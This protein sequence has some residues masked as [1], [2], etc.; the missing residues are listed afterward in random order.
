MKKEKG[1]KAAII[2][3]GQIGST[4]DDDPK[5]KEIWS[6]AGAYGAIE[7]FRSI[8]G[9]DVDPVKRDKFGKRDKVTGVYEDYREMLAKEKIDVLSICSPTP[10]HYEMAKEAL[11]HGLSAI[12]MEKPITM[13]V[14]QGKEI[15]SICHRKKVVLAV[16]HTRRW[17]MDY[18]FPKRLIEK[19]EIGE[20]KSIIGYYS[21]KILNIGTHLID[22]MRLYAGEIKWVVGEYVIKKLEDPTLS[23]YFMFE[24]GISGFLVP[25][26][27]KETLIFELDIIGS[28]GRM[29]VI[30]NGRICE[31]Y[32]Y[33]NSRNYSGYEELER[34]PVNKP[35][36]QGNRLIL[37]IEDII[38][39][40]EGRNRVPACS[41]EDGLKNIAVAHA[42]I[43]SADRKN[44]KVNL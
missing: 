37:A 5:R 39:C 42:L 27:K 8:V 9:S 6:H 12:F 32:K 4:F 25:Q 41:G 31:L 3:L 44:R 1:Y 38:D 30:D 23:G 29:R 16:N 15:V 34:R 18:L 40:F 22:I 7:K 24:Q 17:D 35:K 21:D 14:A 20:V 26:G 43:N 36:K 2:G 19:G 10:F 33:K 13:T 11:K 28:R